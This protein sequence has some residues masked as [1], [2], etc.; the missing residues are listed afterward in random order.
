MRQSRLIA[1]DG[2]KV[3]GTLRVQSSGENM[4]VIRMAAGR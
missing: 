1:A 3:E 2:K 4:L